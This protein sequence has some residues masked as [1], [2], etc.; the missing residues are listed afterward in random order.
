MAEP[1]EELE[2]ALEREPVLGARALALALDQLEAALHA[3][4]L[5]AHQQRR[6][7]PAAPQEP[8][9][10]VAVGDGDGVGSHLDGGGYGDPARLR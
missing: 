4:R 8:Q 7:Q 1:G 3:E 6:A 2:L 10:A 5:V 9:H